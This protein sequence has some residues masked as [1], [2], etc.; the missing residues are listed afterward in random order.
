MEGLMNYLRKL[1]LII[2]VVTSPVSASADGFFSKTNEYKGF[3]WFEDE[4]GVNKNN[5]HPDNSYQA[6][7]VEEAKA[8]IEARKQQLDEARSR[9]L[10]IGFDKNAPSS[11]LRQ[12]IITYKKLEEQMWDGA[13]RMSNAF[14]MANFT[15]PELADGIKQP[16]NVYG[17]KIQRRMQ[18]QE[19]RQLIAAFAQNFDLVL[20]AEDNC[21]YCRKFKPVVQDF[22]SSH[23]FK[24]EQA[25]LNSPAGKMAQLL[26]I[27]SVPTLVVVK[28]D[29]TQVFELSRGM[30]TISGLENSILLAT[31]Y[32]KE[33]ALKSNHKQ[34]SKAK[35]FSANRTNDTDKRGSHD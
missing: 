27:N 3:Y 4:Q 11:V 18:E 6:P 19:N 17:V 28:K 1:L 2:L 7:T 16:T 25:A 5:E 34:Q 8:L 35:K 15:H 12:A 14:E 33:L 21:L 26:G 24:L 31:R 22:A 30:T 32:S 9:M 29:G 10:A 23:N 20:F 13:F